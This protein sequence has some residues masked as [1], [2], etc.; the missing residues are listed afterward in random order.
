MN[1]MNIDEVQTVPQLLL[2]SSNSIKKQIFLYMYL[3]SST[4]VLVGSFFW[5]EL[6]KHDIRCLVFLAITTNSTETENETEMKVI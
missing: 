3:I 4:K 1:V 5:V 2:N 6:K